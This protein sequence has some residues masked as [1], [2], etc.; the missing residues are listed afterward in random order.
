MTLV[1]L[2]LA[3]ITANWHLN[4]K[5]TQLSVNQHEP[6]YYHNIIKFILNPITSCRIETKPTSKFNA[7]LTITQSLKQLKVLSLQ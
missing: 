1:K 3:V 4:L 6:V 2:H 5:E 7:K